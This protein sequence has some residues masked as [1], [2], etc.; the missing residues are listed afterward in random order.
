MNNKDVIDFTF[1][2]FFTIKIHLIK[3]NS[4]LQIFYFN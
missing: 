1:L 3:I 2:T 4:F